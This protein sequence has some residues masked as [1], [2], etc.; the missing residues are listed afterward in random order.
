MP[1]I[2]A[3][4]NVDKTPENKAESATRET[5]P[6]REGAIWDNTPICVPRDPKLPNPINQN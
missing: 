3:L 4:V 2:L 6:A 5:S 1:A